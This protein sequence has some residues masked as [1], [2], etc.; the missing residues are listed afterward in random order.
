MWL[1]HARANLDQAFLG[2][3]QT[4]RCILAD[5]RRAR[6]DPSDEPARRRYLTLASMAE[7]TAGRAISSVTPTGRRREAR[8]AKATKHEIAINIVRLPKLASTTG[9][10]RRRI[11]RAT[12]R[13]ADEGRGATDRRQHRA[14][15]GA[16]PEGGARFRMA[17]G[18]VAILG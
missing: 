18:L 11:R 14:A 1:D 13:G 6:R 2:S 15:A 17:R 9:S 8:H 4:R 12:R 16:V 3:S 7:L 10:F 5:A